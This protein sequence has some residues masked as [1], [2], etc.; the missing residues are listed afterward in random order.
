MEMTSAKFRFR[1]QPLVPRGRLLGL[2]ACAALLFAPM[3]LAQGKRVSSPPATTPKSPGRPKAEAA[4]TPAKVEATPNPE[5]T[6]K[7]VSSKANQPPMGSRKDE[8]MVDLAEVVPSIV[9]ELRYATARNITG[10]PIYP[11]KARCL[12]RASTAE[13]LKKAQA[14]LQ[15]KKL[16]LKIWDAYR[17]AWVQK[18]L[19]EAVKNPEYVGEPSRGG[20]LHTYGAA[21]DVTLVDARGREVRMPTDFDDFT[22]AAS[23][24]YRGKDQVVA[25]NLYHLQKAMTNAGFWVLKD[26]WWHFAAED[27][28]AFAP[29][30][31]ALEPEPKP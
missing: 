15:A 3:L 22:P 24:T 17:P 2:A 30:D 4:P 7:P 9:I 10:K 12:V 18:V 11:A 5:A 14:E 1:A 31:M 6:P 28:R 26:E 25:L 8:P 23:R 20:S 29:V 27:V 16:G 19:W 13:R 21:V